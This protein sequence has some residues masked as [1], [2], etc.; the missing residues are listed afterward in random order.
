MNRLL[1]EINACEELFGSALVENE[2]LHI[3]TKQG[4]FLEYETGSKTSIYLETIDKLNNQ[5]L[6]TRQVYVTRA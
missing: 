6:L 1:Y 4:M 5:T 3:G 2:F